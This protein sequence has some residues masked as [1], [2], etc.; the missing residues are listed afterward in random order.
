MKRSIVA[1]LSILAMA[2]M[3]FADPSTVEIGE[4]TFYQVSSVDHMKWVKDEVSNG[5]AINVILTKDIDFSNTT[6]SAMTVNNADLGKGYKG[7]FD[8]NGHTISGLKKASS[9][10]LPTSLFGTIDTVGVVKNLTIANSDFYHDS[11]VGAIAGVNY[12]VIDNVTIKNDVTVTGGVYAGGVVG[13]NGRY[14]TTTRCTNYGTVKGYTAGGIAGVSTGVTSYCKNFGAIKASKAAGGIVGWNYQF[15]SA[16][17]DSLFANPYVEGCENLGTVS[18]NNG[19]YHSPGDDS[20]KVTTKDQAYAGGIVGFNERGIVANCKNTGSVDGSSSKKKSKFAGGVV[21]YNYHSTI[22]NSFSATSTLKGSSIGGAVAYNDEASTTKYCYYDST[23]IAGIKPI[24]ENKQKDD[25]LALAFGLPTSMMKDTDAAHEAGFDFANELN[26]NGYEG[27]YNSGAWASAAN[28]Y[29][30]LTGRNNSGSFRITFDGGEGVGNKVC[31]TDP[32]THKVPK[33]CFPADPKVTGQIFNGWYDEDANLVNVN[34]T[35]D[36]WHLVVAKYTQQFSITFNN[37]DGSLIKRYYVNPDSKFELKEDLKPVKEEDEGNT[38]EFAG[39]NPEETTIEKVS[40][41]YVFTAVFNKVAKKFT[42]TFYLNDE[43]KCQEE[44]ERNVVPSCEVIVPKNTDQYTYTF[45]DFENVVPV[46]GDAEYRAYLDSTLNQY[47]ITYEGSVD[48]SKMYDYDATPSCDETLTK[49]DEGK[50]F[51]TFVKWED[52]VAVVGPAVYK[53]LFN[54]DAKVPMIVGEDVV[55]SVTV[56]VE[57]VDGTECEENPKVELPGYGKDDE[58]NDRDY[59]CWEVNGECKQPGDSVVVNENTVIVAK[60]NSHMITF[61]NGEDVIESCTKEYKYGEMPS[62]EEVPVKAADA[63]YTYEFAGW[64]PEI[65]KVTGEATYKAVFKETVKKY[66]IT[67]VNSENCSDKYDYGVTPSCSEK[68][69]KAA[70]DQ[71]RFEFV[72]WEKEIP[73]VEDTSYN[74]LYNKF[75]MIDVVVEDKVVDSVKVCVETVDGTECDTIVDYVLP[76]YPEGENH[77]CWDVNGECKQPGDSVVVNKDTEIKA[78]DNSY[79]VTFMNGEEVHDEQVVAYN[80][81]AQTPMDP[82]REGSVFKGWDADFSK[83]VKNMTINAIFAAIDTVY[84][85][86]DEK[87]VDSVIVAEGDSV[88]YTLPELDTNKYECWAVNGKCVEDSVIYVHAG[89]EIKAYVGE[90]YV[91]FFNGEKVIEVDT[92]EYKGSATAPADSTVEAP[93]GYWFNGWDK[94]FSV[95]TADLDVNAQF[96][97]VDT[98]LVIVGGDTTKIPV[99]KGDSVEYV[100]G[101]CPEV[102]DSVCVGWKVND[103]KDIHKVGDT[104]YVHGGDVI[105]PVYEGVQAIASSNFGSNFN[106]HVDGR[107]LQIMGAKIGSTL[108]V[109]DLQGRVIAKGRVNNAVE[110]IQINNSGSYLV[111]VGSLT[112]RVTLR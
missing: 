86:I 82:V 111:K 52:A 63:L 94:D 21:G 3:S 80:D 101:E 109:F 100:L 19:S 13:N 96:V 91:T 34:T 41:N 99:A 89:D 66:M 110:S 54:K 79:T 76:E 27:G 78:R 72:S 2:A 108:A 28:D 55:G 47:M 71:Y 88:E 18:N 43:V 10:S 22:S 104:I 11:R 112:K 23:L 51:Y 58:G 56:C 102:A 64:N 40:D 32:Q 9:I 30:V 29:P 46:T 44:Y 5:K 70:E 93:E 53:A 68:P 67:Y 1:I 26:T 95:I 57:R 39:W 7:I 16:T 98:A 31:W 105:V 14:G 74:A 49:E 12:G 60:N 6:W 90:Y 36:S 77:E 20:F 8:G 61:K 4:R 81:S 106:L 87:P 37:E 24:A 50:Y 65:V 103:D 45:K 97:K 69:A 84:I 62:C 73:V 17:K 33:S 35:Y 85:V 92:V 15:G 107:K 75:A 42:V 59:E 83:V 48:C 25:S 38:Y